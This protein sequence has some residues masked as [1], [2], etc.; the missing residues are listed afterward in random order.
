VNTAAS[1]VSPLISRVEQFRQGADR[2]SLRRG[3]LAVALVAFAVMTVIAIRGLGSAGDE[4]RWWVVV[5]AGAVGTLLSQF[6][7][8]LEFREIGRAS[9]T[10]FGVVESVRISLIGSAAN[11]L[12]VP[13]SVAVR[14]AAINRRGG[15]VRRG[16]Q[17]SLGVGGYFIGT[18]FV[19]AG[20]AQVVVGRAWLG[21]LWVAVGCAASA[22]AAWLLR[23]ASSGCGWVLHARVVAIEAALI[24]AGGLRM[25]LVLIGLGFDVSVSQTVGLTVAGAMTTAVGFFPAGLGIREALI[26]GISPL[27][28]LSVSAGLAAGVVDRVFR[29]AMLA[30]VALLMLIVD[31]HGART[32]DE[33]AGDSLNA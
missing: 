20:V 9:G 26:A 16:A 1:G 6:L 29:M 32:Q 10:E 12:P 31:R 33:V 30:T 11:L 19:V 7:N 28:G 23:P 2:P 27:V 4:A 14:V 13:G 3:A 21:A 5:L 24:V 22:T 15:G 17:M 18:T 25:W 8:S